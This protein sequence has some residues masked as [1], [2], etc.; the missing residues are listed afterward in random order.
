MGGEVAAADVDGA[1]A[2]SD[3]SWT[4]ITGIVR[5]TG[6]S[7]ELQGEG[8][9]KERRIKKGGSWELQCGDGLSVRAAIGDGLRLW[10]LVGVREFLR[11]A[12]GRREKEGRSSEV[13]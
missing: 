1:R 4:K 10:E 13:D 12:G 2:G 5:V 6:N 11:A 7:Y 3:R 8:S 9:E